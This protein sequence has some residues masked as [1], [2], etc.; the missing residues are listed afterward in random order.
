MRGPLIPCN[1]CSPSDQPT[2]FIPACFMKFISTSC[3]SLGLAL[4]LNGHPLTAQIKAGQPD[5]TYP[6]RPHLI[7]LT[8]WPLPSIIISLSARP[9]SAFASRTGSSWKC[10]A[11]KFQPSQRAAASNATTP[12]SAQQARTGTGHSVS[13]LSKRSIRV[14]S[15]GA[16]AGATAQFGCFHPY[17]TGRDQR[18]PA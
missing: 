5:P 16:G 11:R 13:R 14:G 3:A 8:P 6:C 10:A 1:P 9:K 18:C 2:S 12:A 15:L 17:V 4:L 7:Y